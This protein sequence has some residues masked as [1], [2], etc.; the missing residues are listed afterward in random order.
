[1]TSA[2]DW[3]LKSQLSILQ[4]L[5]PPKKKN[6]KENEKNETKLFFSFGISIF[7]FHCRYLTLFINIIVINVYFLYYDDYV[8]AVSN[9]LFLLN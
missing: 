3:V 7:L 9:F 5:T 4:W 6:Q 8:F 2:V 1:M